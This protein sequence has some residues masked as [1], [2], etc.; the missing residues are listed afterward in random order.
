MTAAV[1]LT[2]TILATEST[3]SAPLLTTSSESRGYRSVVS[4]DACPRISRIAARVPSDSMNRHPCR[5]QSGDEDWEVVLDSVTGA[6]GDSTDGRPG[7]MV[8]STSGMAA[9]QRRDEAGDHPAALL[10]LMDGVLANRKD[11]RIPR[12]PSPQ[13]DSTAVVVAQ[14]LPLVHGG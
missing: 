14:V 10:S 1:S 9:N 6:N 8:Q 11:C 13:Q 4:M 7:T 2:A 12:T 3:R 5:S